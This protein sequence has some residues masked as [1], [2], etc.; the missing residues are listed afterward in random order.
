MRPRYLTTQFVTR[1]AAVAGVYAALTLALAPISFGPLQLRVA[2]GLTVLPYVAAPAVPGLF[3][4]CAL[5]NV[6]G[7]FG[8]PDV[9]FGSLA[10]LLA[11]LL[12]RAFAR[13]RVPAYIVPLPAVVINALIVP[14]YLRVLLNIPYWLTLT[15]VA[16]GQLAACYGLGYPLLLLLRRRADL[17]DRLR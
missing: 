11:A 10:T 7:G 13:T 12:T 2:E 14:A 16:A 4:G 17:A 6:I 3:I 15:Q 8:W 1:T 9:V 5:A